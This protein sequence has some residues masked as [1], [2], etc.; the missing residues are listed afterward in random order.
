MKKK[1]PIEFFQNNDTL[2][3]SRN[4]LGKYLVSSIDNKITS[5]MI[6]ET[7]GYLGLEDRASHAFSNKRSNRTEILYLP[8]GHLYV[9]LCYGIH[10][11]VNIV[12]Q[13]KD[14][15]HGVLI[16]ALEPCDGTEWMLQRRHMNK[17]EHKLTSGPGSLSQAMGITTKFSG[18][19]LGK[20]VW[21]EDRGV[22]INVDQIIMSPRVG[23]GYAKEHALLPYRFQI[24][25]NPWITK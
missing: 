8:G 24:K 13:T 5:G 22:K 23:V 10:S 2:T 7:E 21:V 12:T 20:N 19:P 6:V 3:I 25:D 1:L 18:E 16:R 11:L 4:L 17:I 9:Y 15:P 14:V